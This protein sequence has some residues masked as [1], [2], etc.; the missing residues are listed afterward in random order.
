MTTKDGH[1]AKIVIDID[2]KDGIQVGILE[3]PK[4]IRR[5]GTVLTGKNFKSAIKAMHKERI[6]WKQ[7]VYTELK[8]LADEEQ[9]DV[10][11]EDV[12]TEAEFE[13]IEK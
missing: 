1:T 4:D 7:K 12:E 5:E 6:I 3:D 9:A 8:K 10:V 13:E 11:E 2:P